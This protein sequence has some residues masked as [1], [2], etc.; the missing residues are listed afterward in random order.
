MAL[1]LRALRP[2]RPRLAVGW[3]RVA[4]RCFSDDD[5]PVPNHTKV[6]P[7]YFDFKA[8][9]KSLKEKKESLSEAELREV[10]REYA[11]PPP[12][13]WTVLSFLERM[14]FGDGAEDVAN[15][16]ENW[17]DFISMSPKDIMRIPDIAADQRR[18]LD[19]Y[20]TLFNHGLW[21]R[22]SEDEFQER[23][24]GARL[25]NEGKPWTPEEDERLLQLARPGEEGGYDVNFGDPWIYLSWELQR[26]EEDVRQRYVE[27][28]VKPRERATRHEFA[29]TKAA[30]P[31]NMSRRF[32]MIPA[33]L[34]I[35]PSEEN[36]PLAQRTFRLPAAFTKYRKEDIF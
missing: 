2:V 33:D 35:V 30:R 28:A 20:I 24:G 27:L 36:F 25:E 6:S 10:R 15:L 1:A 16:F 19:R 4:R 13:G 14:K 12:Q 21:P 3:P 18:K 22:V 23:F 5:D 31:L 34:Y 17:K 26:R 32:R 8:F 11:L 7:R 29:I 9:R